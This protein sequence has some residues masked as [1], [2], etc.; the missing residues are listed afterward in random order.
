MKTRLSLTTRFLPAEHTITKFLDSETFV[1]DTKKLKVHL[2]NETA[3]LVWRSINKKY[4][5]GEIIKKVCDEYEVS[6]EKAE[7]DLFELLEKYLD[8]KIIVVKK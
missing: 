4:S 3:A 8:Q 7:K 1:F 6:G 5:V 2:L